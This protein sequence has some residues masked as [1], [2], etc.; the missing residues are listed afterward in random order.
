MI[1]FGGKRIKS[2]GYFFEPTVVVNVTHDMLLMREETF[3]PVIPIMAVDNDQQAIQLANDTQYGLSASVWCG[4]NNRAETIAN[5]LQ[6]GTVWMN[7]LFMFSPY[8]PWGG[9]KQS[10]MGKIMSKY[11]VW[12]TMDAKVKY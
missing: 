5:A 3:G 2:D 7:K 11:G 8:M 6:A 10:G 1:L 12:E 9:L 4:D